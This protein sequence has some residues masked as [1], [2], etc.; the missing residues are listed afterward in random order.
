[1]LAV[2]AKNSHRDFLD[3]LHRGIIPRLQLVG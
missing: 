1:M 3:R 2:R